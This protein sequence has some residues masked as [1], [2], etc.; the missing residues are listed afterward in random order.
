MSDDLIVEATGETVGEAK[1]AALR[2][3]ERAHPAL[4]KSAVRFEVVSEGERGLLGVGYEP[5]RVLAHLPAEAAA[6]GASADEAEPE[7]QAAEA[8]WLVS[9]I[10]SELGIDGS[11]DV[12]EGRDT[13]TVTVSG[14]DVAI[15]I[16]RHGQTI[17]AIQYL[18][19]VIQYRAHGDA[20]KDVVVD[21]AGYRE[22]RRATLEALADEIAERVRESGQAEE[23]EP[24]TSV[25]RKI[26]HLRLKDAA[27]VATGSEG[28]EPNRYVVV[29]PG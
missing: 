29:L 28:T 16:G 21:A 27:G 17:D 26:V 25:E 13:I 23:L 8:R 3:L 9:R 2:E 4:D 10:A 22:R 5:A 15:L 20:K 6:A 18:L 1:W 24:M 12:D 7:G 14:D 11:L 19:N